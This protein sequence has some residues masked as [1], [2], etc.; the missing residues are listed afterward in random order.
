MSIILYFRLSSSQHVV[1][2]G[3]CA[4]LEREREKITK[5]KTPHIKYFNY[6]PGFLKPVFVCFSDINGLC[7]QIFYY[8]KREAEFC[9]IYFVSDKLCT[10]H[11]T[12]VKHRP[13]LDKL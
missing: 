11:V 10:M 9:S 1:G 8:H 3:L 12:Y 13:Q 6:V 2:E 5:G 7:N 4:G